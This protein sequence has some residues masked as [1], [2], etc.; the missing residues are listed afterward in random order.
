MSAQGGQLR[1]LQV[2]PRFAPDRG[3]VESHV[4]HLSRALAD[5]GVGV[6]VATAGGGRREETRDGIEVVRFPSFAPGGNYHLSAGLYQLIRK[7]RGEFDIIHAHSYHALTTL[8]AALAAGTT[9]LVV[10]PHYHGAGHSRFRDLLHVPYRLAGRWMLSRAASV[11]AVSAAERDL[12]LELAP[13]TAGRLR[14]VSNGIDDRYLDAAAAV[15][16]EQGLVLAVGRLEAYK[17]FDQAIRMLAVLP[18]P[19]HLEIVGRG[20]ERQSL[21]TLCQRLGVSDRVRFRQDLSGD[22]LAALYRRAQV[23]V[24]LSDHE[25]FG[26]TLLEAAACGCPV[27][28]SDLPSHR[29][30]A[31]LAT[32]MMLAPQVNAESVGRLVAA[33]AGTEAS[34]LDRDALRWSAI[35]G[36]VLDIYRDAVGRPA[37]EAVA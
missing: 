7:H 14:Q 33:A 10:T 18:S 1:V 11:I 27:V 26:L 6:T 23:Y 28:A 22:E 15:E 3:G 2:T 17:R 24:S 34:V 29:E 20:P 31:S 25:A 37:P 13:R 4:E 21:D 5:L 35:A 36:R 8:L 9:P 12:L 19:F 32:G 30:L 16:R